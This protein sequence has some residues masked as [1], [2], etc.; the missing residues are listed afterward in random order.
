MSVQIN[1]GT[2]TVTPAKAEAAFRLSSLE[3]GAAL[4][5]ASRNGTHTSTTSGLAPSYLQANLIILPSR[6]AA[7]FR[8]LCAR[9]PVPCPLLAESSVVGKF[10]A[11][12]SWIDGLSGDEI[13]S[14]FDIRQ[15]VPKYM[16][17]RDSKLA[18]SECEEIVE[19]WTEDHIAFLIGCSFSFESALKNA[20]L[21]PRHSILNRTVPIYRTNI[22]LCPAGVF[23][24]STYVVSMRP[25]KRSE[26]EAVRDITRPYTATHGEPIAW[27][28]DALKRLGIKNVDTPEWGAP[29]L[30]LDGRPLG[31]HAGSEDEIPVFWGCG[32]TPQEAVMKAGLEGTIM[33]HAPGHMLGL[34]CRDWDIVKNK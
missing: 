33:A 26:I 34:D 2:S 32:V 20:G 9:N 14:R 18:K 7:D 11:V 22:P 1:S 15:D 27:G 16:V 19:E 12:K 13:I 3:T 21:E 17:Y 29:P 30:T 25:Y 28:W 23:T 31:E 8:L 6:Y 24:S 5:E 10:D 4:R